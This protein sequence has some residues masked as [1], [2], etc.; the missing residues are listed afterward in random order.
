MS[1]IDT[2][3]QTGLAALDVGDPLYPIQAHDLYVTWYNAKIAAAEIDPHDPDAIINPHFIH[4]GV[5]MLAKVGSWLGL[6]YARHKSSI[7]PFLDAAF[8]VTFNALAARAGEL[9][10]LNNRG[11]T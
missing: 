7:D 10:A 5:R 4:D 6:F 3:Y 1:A 9:K 2:T 11:P 8:I